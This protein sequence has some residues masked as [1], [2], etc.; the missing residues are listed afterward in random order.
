MKKHPE[1][2]SLSHICV[3]VRLVDR[4][5]RFAR[6]M[7]CHV[8]ARR[9]FRLGIGLLNVKCLVIALPGSVYAR[10]GKMFFQDAHQTNAPFYAGTVRLRTT[11][12]TLCAR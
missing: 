10:G 2:E 11:P 7:D 5:F 3:T 12:Q 1:L 8:Y 6:A 4:T 9:R